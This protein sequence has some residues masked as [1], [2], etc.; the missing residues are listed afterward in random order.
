M[1]KTYIAPRVEVNVIN[2]VQV[3][4][5]S[6]LGVKGTANGTESGFQKATKDRGDYEPEDNASFGDLW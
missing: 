6:P 1:K 5:G 3:I 4:C 2:A